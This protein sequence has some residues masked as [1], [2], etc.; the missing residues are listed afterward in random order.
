MI[1]K[2]ILL[3][4]N[5]YWD[6]FAEQQVNQSLGMSLVSHETKSRALFDC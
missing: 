1:S 3:L 6:L 5:S 2:E 4:A